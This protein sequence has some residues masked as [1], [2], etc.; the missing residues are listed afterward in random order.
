MAK[1]NCCKLSLIYFCDTG[2]SMRE[3]R[4]AEMSPSIS[5][6]RWKRGEKGPD[7][8]TSK[9]AQSAARKGRKHDRAARVRAHGE[10]EKK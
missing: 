5:I 7:L 8:C 9:T 1:R 4:F 10:A 6:C 3:C 2:D